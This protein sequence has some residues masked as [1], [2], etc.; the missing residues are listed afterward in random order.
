MIFILL[1]FI[2]IIFY[3][4]LDRI[5]YFLNLYDYPDNNIKI[6]S[7]RTFIGGGIIFYLNLFII[8]LYHI[9]IEEIFIMS[10]TLFII[11]SLFFL[12]GLI[13]DKIR[14]SITFRLI[15]TTVLLYIF[16]IFKEEFMIKEIFLNFFDYKIN[17]HKFSI[18][19]TIICFITLLN[20]MNMSDGIN[21]L[22]S[23]Y[24]FLFL[25]FLL[26]KNSEL[27]IFYLLFPGLLTFLILN[28][29]GRVFLGDSGIYLIYFLIGCFVT[30]SYNSKLIDFQNI[31]IIFIIPFTDMIRVGAIRII[32][33]R[34][35]M[36][37]D[38]NHLHHNLMAKVN[39]SFRTSII[40]ISLT[41]I[42]LIFYEFINQFT[43]IFS[44]QLFSYFFIIFFLKNKKI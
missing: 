23:F 4:N 2:N 9:Y 34:S 1:I 13:D 21:N 25:I 35:P 36:F 3:F 30:N 38:N 43:I 18:L 41:A 37:G 11:S 16:F 26:F 27:F 24:I 40:I 39:S 5:S 28:Y 17:L 44:I 32:N 29:K 12:I 10:K 15:S 22:S 6:H 33:S 14:L 7:N 42:P 8:F 31:L 20:I 19:F